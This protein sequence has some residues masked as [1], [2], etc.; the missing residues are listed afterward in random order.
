MANNALASLTLLFLVAGCYGTPRTAHHDGGA[1]APGT[2]GISGVGGRAV[3]AG[4]SGSAGAAGS[5]GGAGTAG[6][7]GSPG[8][9]GISGTPGNGGTGGG[10]GAGAASG[11]IGAPV[12]GSGGIPGVAGIGG[13]SGGSGQGGSPD[14]PGNGGSTAG[15]GTGGG[16]G[17]A[18]N[19]A[20]AGT[21]GGLAG[22]NGAETVFVSGP[23][24]VR[25]GDVST[26]AFGRAA[27]GSIYRRAYDGSIWGKWAKLVGLG[28][29]T[30]ARSDLDCS[31]TGDGKAIHIV[32]TGL[33]PPGA[34]LHSFGAANT[35]NRFV[36]EF[37]N[38]LFDPSPAIATS[39]NMFAA[40]TGGSAKLYQTL[41]QSLPQQLTPI[42]TLNGYFLSAPD[43]DVQPTGAS[44]VTYFV[45][46]DDTHQ[47]AINRWTINSGGYSWAEPIRLPPPGASFDFNPSVCT[48]K[49]T[50]G[51]LSVN[52]AAVSGGKL[53][54]T[55]TASIATPFPGWTKI[56]DDA[57]SSPDCAVGGPDGVI[58]VAVLSSTGAILDIRGKGTTWATTNLGLP[59][60]G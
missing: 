27:D 10:A 49:G 3:A 7:G 43:V 34:F 53:W 38:E 2:G 31:A 52:I 55:S 23:C 5:G 18:G 21:T 58:D 36:R 6:A 51:S 9:G 15:S 14:K 39:S 45:G 25:T 48:E 46:V 11:G 28:E 41:D 37:G 56:S 16:A 33:N 12:A 32:A 47:L 59:P 29:T 1:G 54:M 42:S 19:G 60:P 26:E 44:A 4:S 30:D 40:T 17:K 8:V 24:I 35:Y 22:G 20:G 57:A 50:W 13:T